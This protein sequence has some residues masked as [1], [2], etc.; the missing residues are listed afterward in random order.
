MRGTG[1]WIAA[2]VLAATMIVSAARAQKPPELVPPRAIETPSVPYP[3]NATGNA[4]VLLELTIDTNGRV[5]NAT[6]AQGDEPF[7]SAALA[8]APAWRFEPAKRG[9]RTVSARIRVLVDFHPPAPP[10]PIADETPKP[11]EP[12]PAPKKNEPLQEV[13]VTGQRKEVG[14]TD[15][16]GGDVRQMP[17]AFGD[18]FRAIDALPGVVPMVSGLPYYFIRGAPP[19]NTGYFIDGVRVP[20]LFHFGVAKAVI[21]P[22]LVDHV[23]FYASGFPARYGRFTGGIIDGRTAPPKDHLHGEWGV[24]LLDAGLI[25]ETPFGKDD[26]GTFLAGGRYGYPGLLLSVLAPEVFLQYGDY[27]ARASWKL[28]DKNTISTF[29]FGSVDA[30]GNKKNGKVEDLTSTQFHR[31]DTRWDH[32]FGAL[33]KVRTAVTLGLDRTA[34]DADNGSGV[35][36]YMVGVRSEWE[37]QASRNVKIRA[38][39]DAWFDHYS[40]FD[41]GSGSNDQTQQNFPTRD[42]VAAGIWL[43]AVIKVTPD[44][45]IIPGAR[46]D[47]FESKPS[48]EPHDSSVPTFDPRLATRVR[49]SKRVTWITSNGI[50]HQPPS[51]FVPVPGF[52]LALGKGVQTA[53]QTTQGVELTLPWDFTLASTVFLNNLLDLTDATVTCGI[54]DSGSIDNS[55]VDQRIRGRT[56]GLE[57]LLRRPLTKKLTGWIAYTLSRSTR[58]ATPPHS[59]GQAATFLSDFDRTHVLNV[60]GAYDLGR[61]WR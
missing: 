22:A 3:S 49:L 16:G 19:G 29:V 52:Q 57:L 45:E 48:A 46:I 41:N 4:S 25:V 31:I 1:K 37:V 33:G 20:L 2:F 58:E 36:D 8:S 50:T 39:S 10:P 30:A 34:Q 24:S 32:D 12:K 21:H 7:A 38:G 27:Q 28:D 51:F 11:D 55:C 54:T 42:D 56:D 59:T 15:L 47:F 5:S 23:D 6:V 26:R 18:A 9:D 44:F 43:D 14:A 17:G 60:V 40:L 35:L 13:T 53:V 61:N